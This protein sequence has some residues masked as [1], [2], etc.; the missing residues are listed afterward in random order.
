MPGQPVL[1]RSRDGGIFYSPTYSD[2]QKFI[3]VKKIKT[4]YPLRAPQK[5]KIFVGDTRRISIAPQGLQHK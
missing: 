3:E 1:I 4:S 2:K 5:L